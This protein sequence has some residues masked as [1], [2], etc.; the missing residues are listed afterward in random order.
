[1]FSLSNRGFG[2]K[3]YFNTLFDITCILNDGY[4]YKYQYMNNQIMDINIGRLYC[5]LRV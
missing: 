3:D 4:H 1:M 5:I 2:Y